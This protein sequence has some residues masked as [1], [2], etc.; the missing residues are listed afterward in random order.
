[1]QRSWNMIPITKKKV[2]FDGNRHRANRNVG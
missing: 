1:M 2:A